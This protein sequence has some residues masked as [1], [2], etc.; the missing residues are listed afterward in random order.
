MEKL[1]P[2]DQEQSRCS[3]GAIVAEKEP[4][5]YQKPALN[6]S[7]MAERL[8]RVDELVN[9][10]LDDQ[11]VEENV[12]E[13]ETLLIDSSEARTQYVG[14][15]QLHADLIEYYNPQSLAAATAPILANVTNT[16]DVGPSTPPQAAD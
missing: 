4:F 6:E 12:R 9:L 3:K 11:L 13:L 14:M 8:D 2:N 5:G 1:D 10:M 15:V 16:I 7:E